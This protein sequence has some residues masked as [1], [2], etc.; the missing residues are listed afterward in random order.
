MQL[1]DILAQTGGLQSMARELGVSEQEAHSGASALA[2]ALMDGFQRQ[3]QSPAAA[4]GG[5]GALLGQLGGGSLLD[6]VLSP[7]PTD[8]SQGNSVLGHV[9]GS[10]DASR[11]VVQSAA[12]QSGLAPSV[13][14]RMLP[15]LAMVA[16]GH[17]AKQQGSAGL[18]GLG[19]LAG[20]LLG[21]RGR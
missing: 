10:K 5:L 15:M 14:K 20:S 9:L 12:S 13:L 11:S 3:A 16:A 19:G 1:M 17:M 7:Q 4:S 18:G 21:G 8:L 6:N 2:P